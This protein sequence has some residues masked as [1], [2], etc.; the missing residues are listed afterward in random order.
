MAAIVSVLWKIAMMQKESA[1]S[2]HANSLDAASTGSQL[3]CYLS[4]RHMLRW[5]SA[6]L[7]I[8]TVLRRSCESIS[9][10]TET[11]KSKFQKMTLGPI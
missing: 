9:V 6:G 2:V 4:S 10:L 11:G 3:L 5:V 8:H 7:H 1:L